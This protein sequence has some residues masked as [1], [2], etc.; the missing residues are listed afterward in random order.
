MERIEASEPY[1][2]SANGTGK[3]GAASLYLG[4]IAGSMRWNRLSSPHG[5]CQRPKSRWSLASTSSNTFS[6]KS[7]LVSRDRRIITLLPDSD[8]GALSAAFSASPQ[9]IARV[10]A[11]EPAL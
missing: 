2:P 1:R 7:A 9:L 6:F 5:T 3:L 10:S 4:L 11:T 8:L